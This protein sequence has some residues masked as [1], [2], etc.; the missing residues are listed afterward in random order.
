MAELPARLR[1]LH[2]ED[3][4]N[5]R[6][7]VAATLRANGGTCDITAV[8]SAAAFL[9]A[10]SRGGFDI[11]LADDRLPAFDGREALA[12]AAERAPET[13]FIFVSGTLGEEAAVE[14][15]KAGATDYVLKQKLT[16][17][18]AAIARAIRE[19]EIRAEHERAAAEVHRLNAELERRV[20]WRTAELA[21]ANASLAAREQE[22][23]EA[24]S[25]L[26]DLIA[27]SPSMIFRID[28]AEFKITYASPNVSWLLGYHPNEVVGVRNIW[29]RLLHPEDMDR[30]AGHLGEALAAC[31]VQIEQEY[32]LRAKDGRV[33]WC[34]SLMRIEYEGKRPAAIL[35]YCGDISDRREAEQALLE[36]EERTRAILR[37]ANDAFV[38]IDMGGRIVHWNEQ[39]ERTF[40]WQREE[41]VGRILADTIVPE[42][43]RKAHNRGFARL[44][45]ADTR[46]TLSR[47]L[48]A[49]ALRRDGTEF[50]VELTIWTSGSAGHRTFNAFVRDITDQ[51]RAEA[52][53]RQAK[54]EAERANRAKS[55]FLS[56]M[57][58]DL[59]TPLNAVLGFAQLLG[60]DDLG[61]AQLECVQQILKGGKHLLELI[62]EVL[63]IARIEA[64]HLSLS[65]EPVGVRDIVRH[66]VDLIGP[67]AAARGIALV[68][69]DAALPECAV[70]ADRQ[71]LSQVLLNLLSNAV[72][73]NRPGGSVTLSLDQRAPG[74]CRISVR[75]TGAGI[76]PEKLRLLF[77]PFERL[78]AESTAIEGTGLGLILSRGLAEAMGGSLGVD[79]EVDRGSTF[80]VELTSTDEA[81]VA[82]APD[83]VARTLDLATTSRPA[84]VLYVEDNASNVRL[85]SRLLSRRPEVSLLHAADAQTGLSLARDR[86]PDV[87]FLDLHLPDASGE[88][89]LRQ[90]WDD[91]ALRTIPVIMLSADATSG[92]VRRLLASGATA[93]LTKPLDLRQVLEVLDQTLSRPVARNAAAS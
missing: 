92:Q 90:L 85:M 18:P 27:A 53:I 71:R 5:D 2:V 38:G 59:R 49:K 66:A 4:P 41:A 20:V 54:D 77:R 86:R 9:E 93:Y 24:K 35:W 91:P 44:L 33:R 68:A 65:P 15:L 25:F 76:S 61:E 82:R 55:E 1:I 7:L 37:T 47:R 56:R 23:H 29:R 42:W 11:I 45:S 21:R 70:L 62:N 26:E 34:F 43:Q 3:D 17:L 73:Y 8:D 36:S 22:L 32:R 58:H 57:S 12:F 83:E 79:S 75:D 30:A 88:D 69:D 84:T 72:K 52:L 81:S 19:V 64:G 78:G 40:G 87:I 28:P 13:P 67:L 48:E 39:A 60:A 6:E 63:D 31:A 16:R 89:V 51:K 14:R 46:Q 10:M 80:W 50:P 74:R